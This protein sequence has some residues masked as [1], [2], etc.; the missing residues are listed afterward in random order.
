MVYCHQDILQTRARPDWPTDYK[1]LLIALNSGFHLGGEQFWNAV[2][3]G[4]IEVMEVRG[5]REGVLTVRKKRADCYMNDQLSIII[6][7]EM[8]KK[9]VNTGREG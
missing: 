3:A 4:E 6:E 9:A 1:G 7:I 2:T 8:L 5:N